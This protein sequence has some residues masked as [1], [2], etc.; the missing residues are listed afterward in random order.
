[1]N[2]RFVYGFGFES[3]FWFFDFEFVY[4][5][6]FCVSLLWLVSSFTAVSW[7]GGSVTFPG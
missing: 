1:M 5:F 7:N 4:D 3:E 6:G 2:R